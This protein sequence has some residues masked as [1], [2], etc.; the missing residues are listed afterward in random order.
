MAKFSRTGVQA[1]NKAAIDRVRARLEGVSER[2]LLQAGNRAIS[3]VR[4]RFEPAAKRAIRTNYNIKAGDLSGQFKVMSGN[5]GTGEYMELA[6]SNRAVPLINFGGRWRGRRSPG[7]TAQIRKGE[8]KTYQSAFI[9][10]INGRRGMYARQFSRD[11]NSPSGRDPRNKL[12]RLTG[13]SPLQM[14]RG[15]GDENATRIAAEMT[16]FLSTEIQR[17]IQLARSKR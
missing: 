17:Q 10:T 13:P 8:R 3:S 5:D 11:S 1:S 7:A 9:A 14:V 12:R 2:R 15:L 4:R 6:A 16:D